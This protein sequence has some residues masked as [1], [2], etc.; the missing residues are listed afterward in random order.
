MAYSI[1]MIFLGITLFAVAASVAPSQPTPE[2]E[3]PIHNDMVRVVQVHRAEP[4]KTTRPH[5]HEM[6]RVML[7]LNAGGQTV[8]H[9]GEGGRVEKIVWKAGQA[10]WSPAAGMH[11]AEITSSEPAKIVEIELH[12]VPGGRATVWPARDPVKA[13][14]GH[15][16]VD[17]ENTQVRV[18]RRRL[19]PGESTA[20]VDHG[21]APR[22]VTYL[23]PH[24][25]EL[26][27][28]DG[29]TRRL[30]RP[31][32]KVEWIPGGEAPLAERNAGSAVAEAI[33]VYLKP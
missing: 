29:A 24:E 12:N 32:A 4:H 5:T 27:A 2:R 3:I 20:L 13:D 31:A 26:R 1:R 28:K 7:Y 33:I 18:V 21:A 16:L 11:T 23:T 8:I 9:T 19:A 14:P 10:L 17:F 15:Y 25:I 30:T 22:I 6:N